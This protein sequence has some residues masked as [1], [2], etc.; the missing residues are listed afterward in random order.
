MKTHMRT[1]DMVVASDGTYTQGIACGSRSP[2]RK[3][4]NYGCL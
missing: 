2:K 3:R 1:A 4:T